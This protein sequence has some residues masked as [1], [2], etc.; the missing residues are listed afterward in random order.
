MA[1]IIPMTTIAAI[2]PIMIFHIRFLFV[3][4]GFG[5]FSMPFLKEALAMVRRFEFT[6]GYL[7][8]CFWPKI[9]DTFVLD[10]N[11]KGKM[12]LTV[13]ECHINGD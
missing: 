4:I 11:C 2:S 9:E 8:C 10:R 5:Y 13:Q 1:P 3:F 12:R 6:G 7:S